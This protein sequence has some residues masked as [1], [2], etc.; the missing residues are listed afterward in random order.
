M[1]VDLNSR[2]RMPSLFSLRQMI[3]VGWLPAVGTARLGHRGANPTYNTLPMQ[4]GVGG[5]ILT[6]TGTSFA[7]L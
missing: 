1:R 6:R 7:T 4:A 3:G 5:V 2:L